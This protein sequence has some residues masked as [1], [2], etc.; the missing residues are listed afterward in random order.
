MRITLFALVKKYYQHPKGTQ[1]PVKHRT[2]I[3]KTPHLRCLKGSSEYTF[4]HFKQVV[5]MGDYGG[6]FFGAFVSLA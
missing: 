5:F 1:N 4:Q 3:G 6:S 2:S